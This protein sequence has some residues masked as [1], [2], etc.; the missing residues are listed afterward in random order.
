[1]GLEGSNRIG[2]HRPPAACKFV[3]IR[4]RVTALCFGLRVGRWS[5]GIDILRHFEFDSHMALSKSAMNV[6]L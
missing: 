2:D 3:P 6:T 4:R 5:V 1:M